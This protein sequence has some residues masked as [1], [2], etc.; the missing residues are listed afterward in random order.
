MRASPLHLLAC[1][2]YPASAFR[3]ESG[4]KCAA[5]GGI[6][7]DGR[8]LDCLRRL[9]CF[10]LGLMRMD[11]R[12]DSSRHTEAVDAITQCAPPATTLRACMRLPLGQLMQRWTS[13]AQMPGSRI[14]CWRHRGR[15][16]GRQ[17]E[18]FQA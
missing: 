9:Q 10:G 16:S 12:Q 17:S 11:L 5:G 8:L 4:C 13:V 3:A 7:A 6:V 2:S 14:I 1:I 15:L 18:M